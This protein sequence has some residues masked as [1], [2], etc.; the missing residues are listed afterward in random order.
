[1][2]QN[3]ASFEKNTFTGPPSKFKRTL[4]WESACEIDQHTKTHYMSP[5][6]YIKVSKFYYTDK[7]KN[8]ATFAF[9]LK[10]VKENELILL[11]TE[12]LNLPGD[13]DDLKKILNL[14]LLKELLKKE[15]VM[16]GLVQSHQKKNDFLRVS[17]DNDKADLFKNSNIAVQMHAYIL[18]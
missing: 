9:N 5:L 11:T 13:S 17:V 1:M 18:D 14:T 12:Q 8:A 10:D 3:G 15:G 4:Y 6:T 7:N 16:L 2:T